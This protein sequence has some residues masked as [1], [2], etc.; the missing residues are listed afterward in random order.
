MYHWNDTE[1]DSISV[2]FPADPKWRIW[3]S[4][5]KNLNFAFGSFERLVLY[6][7][8]GL[9]ILIDTQMPFVG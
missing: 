3:C 1:A 9:C 5:T 2:Y 4:S 6:F 7:C 8:V